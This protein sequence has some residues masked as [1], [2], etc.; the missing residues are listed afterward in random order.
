[1]T[2]PRLITIP[3]FAAALVASAWAAPAAAAA[4][5]CTNGMADGHACRRIGLESRL[6]VSQLAYGELNDVWGWTD[7][8]GGREYALVGAT[9]GTV[10]VD[11]TDAANPR[12]VGRLPAHENISAPAREAKA[13]LCKAG[14]G[15]GSGGAQPLHEDECGGDSSWR[16]I[17]VY[18]DHAYIGSE[19]AGHGLQIFDLTLLRGFPSGS[20]V[21]R[22]D[23]TNHYG[24]FGHSHTLI[25]NEQT[26]F[27]YAVGSDT[28]SGGPHIVDL[29]DPADPV[30]AG[31]YAGDGYSHEILCVVYAGPDT[32]YTGREICFGSNTDTLTILDVTNKG[33]IV[34]ISRTGYGQVGYTHQGWLTADHGYMFMNDEL[35]ELNTH[36]RTRTLVWDL[37]NLQAPVVADQI[38]QPRFSIDHNNYL[39]QGFVYQSDYTSGLVILDA[40]D[41][42]HAF[43]VAYFDTS[44]ANDDPIFDG[45][46]SN[47][48]WFASGVVAVSDI[49]RGL[50]LLR[51]QLGGA[52]QDARLTLQPGS[53]AS[54]ARVAVEMPGG[55]GQITMS[56]GPGAR[57]F[58]L[59]KSPPSLAGCVARNPQVFVCTNPGSAS[60]SLGLEL[61]SIGSGAVPTEV[62]IMISGD[63]D[64]TAPSDNRVQ[65]SVIAPVVPGSGSGGG[66]GGVPDPILLAIVAAFVVRGLRRNRSHP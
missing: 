20:P 47:Y 29:A 13:L 64:E 1:M 51:P 2:L 16:N 62:V 44:P 15:T 26:G 38:L 31:G 55:I 59:E 56:V 3:A 61:A 24:G 66:G 49:S 52:T 45:T 63:G 9:E 40:R 35:D 41:P 4:V 43:E 58:G 19:S 5:A 18:R 65:A 17:K 22:F 23:E 53:L 12:I 32:R 30:A 28:F 50:Y 46:W 42:L 48:P 11:I 8:V 36:E 54:Q 33:A 6:T 10:F 21:Q 25:V 60:F 27:L 57:F 7:P 39:H 37:S 14:A 34:Q